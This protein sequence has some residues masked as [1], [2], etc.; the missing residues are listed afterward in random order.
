MSAGASLILALVRP[1]KKPRM[2]RTHLFALHSSRC[3]RCLRLP[4][5]ADPHSSPLLRSFHTK[6]TTAQIEESL[7]A[8]SGS[9]AEEAPLGPS[10]VD[11]RESIFRQSWMT[12]RLQ[13]R[14]QEKLRLT[15]A[16]VAVTQAVPQSAT[17]DITRTRSVLVNLVR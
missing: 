2:T 10:H 14:F 16:V 15:R 8:T 9:L 13:T 17:L 6:T 12:V 1:E 3:C 7:P 4:L 11:L 5:V